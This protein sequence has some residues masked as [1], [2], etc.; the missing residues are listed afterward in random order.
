MTTPTVRVQDPDTKQL[1]TI[2]ASELAPGMVKVRVEP[3]GEEY[4][5]AASSLTPMTDATSFR[6]PP[7]SEEVRD[8]LRTI[9]DTFAD[10]RPLSLEG[11]EGGFRC[12]AHPEKEIA[13]WLNIAAA[14]RHLTRH[15]TP[16]PTELEKKRDIFQLIL[17]SVNNGPD[18]AAATTATPTLSRKRVRE[19]IDELKRGNL[20]GGKEAN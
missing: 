20:Q 14:Y 4:F 12:D 17:S 16:G 19:I 3:T 13:L 10:V 15:L 8:L 1:I 11:W 5:V 6:H 2:P 7:F 9:R 18:N